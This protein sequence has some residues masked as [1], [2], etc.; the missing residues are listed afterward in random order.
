MRIDDSQVRNVELY[1]T[2]SDFNCP[3]SFN[4][5]RLQIDVDD[6]VIVA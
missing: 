1:L 3:L 6:G 2:L 4:V 5:I